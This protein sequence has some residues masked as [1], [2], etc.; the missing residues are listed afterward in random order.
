MKVKGKADKL[1]GCDVS[2]KEG[3]VTMA[4]QQ[5]TQESAA[6]TTAIVASRR[7]AR[8]SLRTKKCKTCETYFSCV[9]Y[10]K[11]NHHFI[12][13][14]PL[15]LLNQIFDETFSFYFSRFFVTLKQGSIYVFQYGFDLFTLK[16]D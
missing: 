7:S 8:Q 13:C 4:T 6:G 12:I 5:P 14:L 16:A 11:L 1:V 9:H 10:S 2:A 15:F 3:C